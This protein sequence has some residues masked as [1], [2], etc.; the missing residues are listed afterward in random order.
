MTEP[1]GRLLV[2]RLG[3]LGDLVHALPAV[4]AIRRAHPHAVIDWFV[5]RVHRDFLDLVPILSSVIVLRQPNAAGWIEAR[6]ELRRRQYEVAIDFQGLVKS[7]VLAR[8]SGAARVVGFSRAAAREPLAALFYTERVK[9]GE[10][11][12]VIDK[13]LR[14]AAVTGAPV[15]RREFPLVAPASAALD[16]IRAVLSGPFAVIN[17]GAAWPNKRWPPERFG[18]IGAWLAD[19]HGLRSVVLWGPGEEGL[20]KSVADASGGASFVA[21]ATGLADV[22]AILR[23]A[24]LMISGDTGPTHIAGAVGTPTVAL[25]G[26]TTP[27]RNGPW[28]PY[29]ISIS[30]YDACDCHYQRTCRRDSGRWCLAS[31]TEDDVRSAID[32]RLQGAVA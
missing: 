31:I 32:R 20:A 12:H 23:E 14:L 8:L 5:D 28:F 30:R 22:V 19:T 7:A 6:R 13:N 18:A 27:G 29:D 16:G 1:I 24:R 21:P 2:V 17:P 25:F 4:A 9:T 26:P 3:S 10:S 15:D 11:G